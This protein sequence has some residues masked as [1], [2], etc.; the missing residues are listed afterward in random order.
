MFNTNIKLY[1]IIIII[2]ILLLLNYLKNDYCKKSSFQPVKITNY[3]VKKLKENIKI[4][5]L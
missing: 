4:I 2:L 5:L 1:E 3:D